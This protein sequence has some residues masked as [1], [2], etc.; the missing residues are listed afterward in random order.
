MPANPVLNAQRWGP[1]AAPADAAIQTKRMTLGGTAFATGVL[2]FL[3]CLTGV[4]GYSQITQTFTTQIVNG[5]PTQVVS[6]A[7]PAIMWVAIIAGLVFGIATA[8][9]PHW[10][11]VTAPLYA[12][13]Y[14]VAVGMISG[15]YELY[16]DG[17]VLQAILAT[18]ATFIVVFGLYVARIIRPTRKVVLTIVAAT[19]GIFLMYL[20][21]FVASIFGADLYFWNNPSPLGIGISVVICIVAAL[22]LIL[23]FGFI[24]G[25]TQ[26]GAPKYMEWY[27]AYGVTVTLVWLYLE[28]LRLL[29]LLNR[30]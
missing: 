22:N 14:G 30:S 3:L 20:V 18:I 2:L 23:D 1:A 26:Q 5:Q 17:I 7:P 19:G 25:A 16:W 12:L 27:G 9:R 6:T 28:I 29:S 24:E 8:L 11:R 10:A 21:A 15:V 4:W 13:C